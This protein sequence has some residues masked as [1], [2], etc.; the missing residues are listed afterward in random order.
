MDVYMRIRAAHPILDRIKVIMVLLVLLILLGKLAQYMEQDSSEGNSNGNSNK[1]PNRKATIEVLLKT[2]L[3]P[4]GSTMYVW[5]GGWNEMDD[6]AGMGAVQIGKSPQ[7]ELFAKEQDETYDFDEHRYE[8]EN[9]LDCSG[10]AGWVIYNTFETESGKEGYVTVSTDMAENFA[11]LGWGTYIKNPKEF[12]PG[13][14]VSMDGHVW[15]SM[16]TCADGSVLLVH[17]SPPGVSVCGTQI[18][19]KDKSI[20]VR[21]AEAYMQTYHPKWQELYPNRMVSDAYLKRVSLMR[22]NRDTMMDAKEMQNLS[23]E[24]IVEMLSDVE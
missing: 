14:I 4:V 2:A 15:I 9:G 20:A 1:N 8:R 12:L 24:E 22:W 13:D 18:E 11:H 10:Y 23:G 21:L 5:G 17:S 6:A 16:G 7:W 19:G 3:Q